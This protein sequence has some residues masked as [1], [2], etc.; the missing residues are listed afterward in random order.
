M[1][2][3]SVSVLQTMRWQLD[4][5][6]EH[7]ASTSRRT[8]SLNSTSL[9]WR[10]LGFLIPLA[11]SAWALA[12]EPLMDS[13]AGAYR[14][15]GVREMVAG[16]VLLSDGRFEYGASYGAVDQHVS[17]T[18][19]G[20]NGMVELRADRPPPAA[21]VRAKASTELVGDYA[22]PQAIPTVLVVR[23]HS[24]AQGLTWSNME[25]TAEFS[26]GRSR[27]GTT[28]RS[29][30]IGFV[31]RT[32]PEWKDAVIK[33]IAVAY[34]KGQVVKRWFPIESA[35]TK[36]L[37]VEFDP[38]HLTAPAFETLHLRVDRSISGEFALVPV[39]TG[40]E[41]SRYVRR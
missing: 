21:F 25:V 41:S 34:P 11:V 29:G 20:R 7:M 30:L 8:R 22:M 40:T 31:A 28:G 3:C 38:G 19:K 12:A 26:N 37:Q 17:G 39:G 32:E 35:R 10:V 24:P 1:R 6:M 27:T 13:F 15:Q 4:D 14:L 9:Q 16:L 36:T 18:W 23:V 2:A 33:R 5:R